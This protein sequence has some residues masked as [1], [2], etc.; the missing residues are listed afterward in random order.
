M[1][2]LALS[3]LLSVS[4]ADFPSAAQDMAGRTGCAVQA[5][6]RC[7]EDDGRIVV[8]RCPDA[9]VGIL[10]K[11]TGDDWLPVARVFIAPITPINGETGI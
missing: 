11:K 7:D 10:W 8:Y 1:V 3:L 9:T 4:D 6:L 5:I 2:A